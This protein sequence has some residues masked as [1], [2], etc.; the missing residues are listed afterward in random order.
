MNIIILL[1]KLIIINQ[2]LKMYNYTNS[3]ENKNNKNKMLSKFFFF[4]ILFTCVAFVLRDS[5]LSSSLQKGGFPLTDILV[6][7][8]TIIF[9]F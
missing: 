2:I 5:H 6:L 3:F 8:Y 7:L 4:N 1:F 9:L